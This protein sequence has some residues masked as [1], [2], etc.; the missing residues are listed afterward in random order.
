MVSYRGLS[1][2]LP[3][4]KVKAEN[5]LLLRNWNIFIFVGI[6]F[7]NNIIDRIFLYLYCN[8]IN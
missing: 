8:M 6:Y 3:Q 4:A 2:E 1:K 5:Y 7:N